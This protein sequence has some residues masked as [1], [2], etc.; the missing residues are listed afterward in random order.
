MMKGTILISSHQPGNV[1]AVRLSARF[2][3]WKIMAKEGVLI[4]EL[5]K[6]AGDYI[7]TYV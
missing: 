1:L 5:T 4:I 7:L 6:P 2:A 3:G